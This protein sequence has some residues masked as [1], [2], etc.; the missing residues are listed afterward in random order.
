MSDTYYCVFNAKGN[1]VCYNSKSL[2]KAQEVVDQIAGAYIVLHD[3]VDG[4]LTERA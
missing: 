3:L 2:K 1:Y 4:I